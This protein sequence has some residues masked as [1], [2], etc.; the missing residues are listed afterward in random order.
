MLPQDY[1]STFCE[2]F[3]IFIFKEKTLS[4]QIFLPVNPFLGA[5]LGSKVCVPFGSRAVSGA[6]MFAAVQ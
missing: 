5:I 3:L 1:K 2:H 4:R 6:A